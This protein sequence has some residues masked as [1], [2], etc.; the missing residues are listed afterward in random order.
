MDSNAVQDRH[1][2]TLTSWLMDLAWLLGLVYL[3]LPRPATLMALAGIAFV[4][5]RWRRW[6]FVVSIGMAATLGAL[7]YQIYRSDLAAGL[8]ILGVFWGLL[9]HLNTPQ[10]A[11]TW[12]VLFT[13][14]EG[15][16][17]RDL[18]WL[19]WVVIILGI[20]YASSELPLSGRGGRLRNSLVGFVGLISLIAA[21]LMT[22]VFW[23]IPWAWIIENTAG[24]VAAGLVRL[25]PSLHLPKHH[26]SPRVGGNLGHLSK[27]VHKA[28]PIETMI[29]SVLAALVVIGVIWIVWS[30]LHLMDTE[31][32]E[33]R[34]ESFIVRE[35]LI[36]VQGHQQ[37]GSHQLLPPVRRLVQRHLR[38]LRHSSY[39]RLRGETLRQWFERVY[40]TQGIPVDLYEQVR[41]G[42]RSDT[43]E[44]AR[45]VAD[46]WP[47]EGSEKV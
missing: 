22:I 11:V 18:W 19:V 28:G 17:D 29:L 45:L 4:A 8:V 27:V 12:A 35:S 31:D 42:A 33:D 16:W 10:R 6:P 39:A 43:W 41:Y 3:C 36:D 21:A 46:H 26:L 24:R 1:W 7:G 30:F 23:L 5:Q 15:F 34:Q 47:K 13:A 32:P 2:L 14:A 25:I 9:G 44:S 40:G 38:K 37:F 20:F